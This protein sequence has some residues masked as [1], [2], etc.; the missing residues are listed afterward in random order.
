MSG[1]QPGEVGTDPV[2][3]DGRRGGRGHL[4][5]R[6]QSAKWIPDIP[7][8]QRLASRR[9]T[10]SVASF[11]SVR[12]PRSLCISLIC[13]RLALLGETAVEHAEY[14]EAPS[15]V[16]RTS[17][18]LKSRKKRRIFSE[19]KARC[20]LLRFPS[21]HFFVPFRPTPFTLWIKAV[22]IEGDESVSA[23]CD[24]SARFAGMNQT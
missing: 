19:Q 2:L 3:Q 21:F 5:Q 15:F 20:R 8:L 17:S 1:Q 22:I 10:P 23:R 16:S 24:N 6:G 12:L 11:S 14:T 4:C 18:G 13:S 7:K 9:A